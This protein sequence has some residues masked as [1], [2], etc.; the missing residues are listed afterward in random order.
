MSVAQA[1]MELNDKEKTLSMYMFKES[2]CTFCQKTMDEL[3]GKLMQC[4]KCKKVYFCS[5]EVRLHNQCCSH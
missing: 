2:C 3:D 4:G 1:K 5:R